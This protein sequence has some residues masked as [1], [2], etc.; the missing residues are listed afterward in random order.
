MTFRPGFAC[1]KLGFALV[2]ASVHATDAITLPPATEI[3]Q[4]PV[5]N[6]QL[7]ISMIGESEEWLSNGSVAAFSEIQNQQTVLL[8]KRKLPHIYRPRLA[9]VTDNGYSVLFDQWT[10]VLGQNAVTIF[11]PSGEHLADYS[12]DDLTSILE[13]SRGEIVTKA[14]VG[15]WMMSRP[16]IA[17][18]G[19]HVQFGV[20]G[21]T[22]IINLEKGILNTSPP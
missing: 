12:L 10:N 7:T 17:P 1:L 20:A 2:L 19:N 3:Y 4:S 15:P 13:V 8:W 9:I 21:K 18:D 14:K 22:L 16:H 5:G 6:Y 11:S